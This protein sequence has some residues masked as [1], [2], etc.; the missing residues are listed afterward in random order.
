MGGKGILELL[1]NLDIEN[2]INELSAIINDPKSSTSKREDALKRLRILKNFDPTIEKNLRDS[3]EQ[4]H[5]QTYLI[6][7]LTL[8]KISSVPVNDNEIKETV[9]QLNPKV[10]N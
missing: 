6:V 7:K 8:S 3:L 4:I 1:R 5:D 9:D 10:I 2:L